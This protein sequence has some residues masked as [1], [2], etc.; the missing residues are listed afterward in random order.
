MNHK[1][2]FVAYEYKT[3]ELPRD[4]ESLY[5][6]TYANFGWHID[7]RTAAPGNPLNTSV[8]LKRDRS[9]ESRPVLAELQRQCDTALATITRLER[10]KSR[11]ALQT[12]LT[13][14]LIG[15]VFMALSVFGI[16][17]W[18]NMAITVAGGAIG[19][20]SW[21]AAYFSHDRAY[22]KRAAKVAP[23]IEQQYAL[24]YETSEQAARLIG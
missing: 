6:D 15:A 21:A 4:L 22:A 11:S 24:V 3:V 8:K 5:L 10:S 20:T 9:I 2:A 23:V 19:L 18:D 14:G 16:T 1:T 13:L 17:E 12:S 7:G